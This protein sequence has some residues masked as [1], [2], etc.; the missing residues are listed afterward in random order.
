M[1]IKKIL[2]CGLLMF[3]LFVR[4]QIPEHWY[5]TSIMTIINPNTPAEKQLTEECLSELTYN[6]SELFV[7]TCEYKKYKFVRYSEVEK[8]DNFYSFMAYEPS[9]SKYW[10]INFFPE[11]YGL[12][13][14]AKDFSFCVI[15]AN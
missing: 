13:L 5:S 4:A 10:Y 14:M 12:A 9:A 3:P 6:G 8:I 1:N 15:Y 2:F 7:E 11:S